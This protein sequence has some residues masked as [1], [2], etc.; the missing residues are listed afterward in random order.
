MVED[1]LKGL[2]AAPDLQVFHGLF[3][4]LS[5]RTQDVVDEIQSI[6]GARKGDAVSRHLST[7][8]VVPIA[9]LT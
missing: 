2:K 1:G 7:P 8:V 5:L 6:N 3:G 4:L 9:C